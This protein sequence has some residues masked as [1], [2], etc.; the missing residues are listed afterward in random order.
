[1]LT[2]DRSADERLRW[3]QKEQTAENAG[4]GSECNER[5]DAKASLGLPKGVIERL[6]SVQPIRNC[7]FVGV[8]QN[9]LAKP[10]LNFLATIDD[11]GW[12]NGADVRMADNGA[13]FN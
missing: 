12:R 11:V 1:M 6:L 10:W 9:S 2:K 8:V 4:N 5:G 7:V 3:L 13:I